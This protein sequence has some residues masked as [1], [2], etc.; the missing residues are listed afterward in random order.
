MNAHLRRRD[1]AALDRRLAAA[2]AADLAYDHPGSTSDPTAWPDRSPTVYQRVVGRGG[3][4]FAA[5][6]DALRRWDTHRAI[7]ARIHPPGATQV[8]G[9]TILLVL[10]RG[11]VEIVVPN[12]VVAV[13]DEPRRC[14]FTYGTLQGH[15]ERGEATFAVT[16]RDDNTVVATILVDAVPASRPAR[17][18]G[19]I[20]RYLARRAN[21]TYLDALQR[22]A[23]GTG[24]V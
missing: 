19:P 12:R 11:P 8:A 14:G 13:V 20:V 23:S 15:D 3:P 22:A 24:S 7:G 1:P 2:Q 6:S 18:L 4:A 17:L 9:T 10:R 5:A 21:T 16:W